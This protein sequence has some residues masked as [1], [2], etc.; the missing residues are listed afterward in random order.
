VQHLRVGRARET[1]EFS[2]L[3][4]SEISWKVSYE[5]PGAFRK[6][7]QKIMGSPSENIGGASELLRPPNSIDA[8]SKSRNH[9]RD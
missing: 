9:Q 6:V 3:S 2:S 4:I 7:F 5:D 1:L 8:H